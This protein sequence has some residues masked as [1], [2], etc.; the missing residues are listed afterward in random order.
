MA[1]FCS[2]ITLQG[3][4]S[5]CGQSSD[6]PGHLECVSLKDCIKDVS[7]HLASFKLSGDE[8]IN[9]EMKLLLARAGEWCHLCY[10]CAISAHIQMRCSA[11]SCQCFKCV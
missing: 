9:T 3:R 2:Y 10:F 4:P 5:T 1:F 8:G 6:Y 11:K 7:S